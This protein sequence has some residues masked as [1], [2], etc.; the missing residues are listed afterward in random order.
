MAKIILPKAQWDVLLPQLKS[1]VPEAFDGNGDILNLTE[2]KWQHTG[3]K[4]MFTSSID[5]TILG[6]Y[7]MLNAKHG[8]TAVEYA[9]KDFNQ[10]SKIPLEE[11]K[12]KIQAV[13]NEMEKNKELLSYILVWEIGKPY[14]Q[15]LNG[16]ERCISGVQWYLDKIENML[17]DRKPLG[18]ISNIASWNYPM[19]VLVHACLV[20]A[21]TG[22]AIIAKT[23][24]DG[25][26]F[27]LTLCFGIAKR[28]GLPFSLISGS[29][30][31]LSESLVA[32][33]AVD[34]LS[35]VGG[36]S[37]GRLIAASL[38]DKKKRYMLEM[39]GVNAYGVW[40]FSDWETLG[41]Q[42]KSG[43]GYGKRYFLNF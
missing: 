27:A 17:G 5:G 38:F 29:G 25:G 37:N 36:K 16:V 3:N 8:N 33:E 30:G 22:N 35:Y 15:A 32:H 40:N 14:D 34:C 20:Q 41:K 23:P 42:V 7:P 24:T 1:N 11:R 39:E 31:V 21:L 6:Y 10:W 28:H 4:K 43:F 18:L 2:G 19:S 12:E 26:L 9:R 13:I